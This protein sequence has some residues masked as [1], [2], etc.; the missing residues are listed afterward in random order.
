[1]QILKHANV[2][3]VYTDQTVWLVTHLE[4]GTRTVKVVF[5]HLQKQSGMEHNVN[6]PKDY[7]EVNV[8]LALLQEDGILIFSNAFAH[9]LRLYGTQ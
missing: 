5:V 1:M 8:W 7:T 2:Q 3:L 4:L 6:A 9:R